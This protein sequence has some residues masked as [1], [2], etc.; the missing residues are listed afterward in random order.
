MFINLNF[1]TKFRILGTIDK[2]KLLVIFHVFQ[3]CITHDQ[4]QFVYVN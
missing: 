3:P 1:E 4:Q 2:F